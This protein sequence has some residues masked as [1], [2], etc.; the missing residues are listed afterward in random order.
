MPCGIADKAVTSLAAE[1]IDAPMRA[2]VDA[3]WRLAEE[4]WGSDGAERTDAAW[5]QSPDDMAA[6]TRDPGSSVASTASSGSVRL[7][8]RLAE[9]GV[10][11]GLAVDERK[12]DWL[13]VPARMG[14]DCGTDERH[15]AEIA[16][17]VN[18]LR[19]TAV[20]AE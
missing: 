13:R 8:G 2:V 10:R 16:R 17:N 20:P 14:A 12:P 9:A 5:R 1:G 11:A 7:T 18:D 3:V 4:R 19:R 15:L 6:F